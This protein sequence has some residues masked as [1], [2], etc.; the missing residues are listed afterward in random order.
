MGLR[1]R[2]GPKIGIRARIT[3]W[4]TTSGLEGAITRRSFRAFARDILEG[5]KT[6]LDTTALERA[7]MTSPGMT[8]QQT[9]QFIKEHEEYFKRRYKI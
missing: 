7:F 3:R 1:R 8:L 6:K 9:I 2:P 5:R 4:S